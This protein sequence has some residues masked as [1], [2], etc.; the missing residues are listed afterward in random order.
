M[1]VY[2]DDA[3]SRPSLGDFSVFGLEEF[4]RRYEAITYKC[5]VQKD[6]P[7]EVS[8]LPVP[9]CLDRLA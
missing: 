2:G 9:D 7:V 6:V 3:I 1:L 5:M 4:I 8:D